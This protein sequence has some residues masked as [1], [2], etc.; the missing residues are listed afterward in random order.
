MAQIVNIRARNITQSRCDD[1]V[2]LTGDDVR[3]S[4]SGDI[5][6]R[7][8]YQQANLGSIAYHCLSSKSVVFTNFEVK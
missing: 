7:F 1:S 4:S 8:C 6:W 3:C 5:H 2:L